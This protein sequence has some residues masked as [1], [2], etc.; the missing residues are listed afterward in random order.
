MLRNI[1]YPASDLSIQ[2]KR[3]WNVSNNPRSY[4]F[5]LFGICSDISTYNNNKHWTI[6]LYW[7]TTICNCSLFCSCQIICLYNLCDTGFI[8][9]F[10]K[11]VN[12]RS[13]FQKYRLEKET[14]GFRTVFNLRWDWEQDCKSARW[15][16]KKISKP[17]MLIKCY[18]SMIIVFD[19]SIKHK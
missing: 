19:I 14:G 16:W 3:S 15:A 13:L 8:H 17:V 10:Y 18:R 4:K 5:L 6:F 2:N 1:F 7:Q 9:R 11:E 12:L